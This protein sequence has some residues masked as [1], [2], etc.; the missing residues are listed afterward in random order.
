MYSFVEEGNRGVSRDAGGER[1]YFTKHHNIHVTSPTDLGKLG[2]SLGSK[3]PL[4]RS[5]MKLK[6]REV[7]GVGIALRLWAVAPY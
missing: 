7:F 1:S 5:S 4:K 3:T 2:D 6:I